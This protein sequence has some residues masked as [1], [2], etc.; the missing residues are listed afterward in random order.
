MRLPRGPRTTGHA[1]NMSE[2]A[3]APACANARGPSRAPLRRR[4]APCR[5]E[6]ETLSDLQ[7]R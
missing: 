4:S 7:D 3:G 5:H 6:G 1:S 2:L